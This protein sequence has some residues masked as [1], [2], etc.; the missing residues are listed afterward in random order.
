MPAGAARV[1]ERD[2]A[3][4][5]RR[6]PHGRA[7]VE[8]LGRRRGGLDR[9][10]LPEAG[11]DDHRNARARRVDPG[12]RERLADAR[13]QPAARPER[14]VFVPVADVVAARDVQLGAVADAEVADPAL[15]PQERGESL[16]AVAQA[17]ADDA[18][19]DLDRHGSNP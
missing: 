3:L 4:E 8:A 6:L 2:D 1:R 11:T 17:R 13:G 10:Q 5:R 18:S 19:R 7:E 14:L 15:A 16:L 9:T 12:R